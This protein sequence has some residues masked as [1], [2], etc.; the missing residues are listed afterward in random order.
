V[1][2]LPIINGKTDTAK[3][4]AKM[5]GGILELEEGDKFYIAAKNNTNRGLYVNILDLQPDGLINPVLP[6]KAFPVEKTELRI[7]AG[8]ERIFPW[9]MKIGPPCGMETYKIFVS[10]EE[11]DMESIALSNGARSRGNLS[12]LQELVN[13]SYTAT[14][15]GSSIVKSAEPDGAVFSIV[16]RIKEKK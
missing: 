2:L 11:I 1:R 8:Q 12:V 10:R 14:S 16:Y 4:N 5:V 13:D 9:I 6:N 7:E 15:R 3:N